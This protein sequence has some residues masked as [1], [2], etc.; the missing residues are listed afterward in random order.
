[1]LIYKCMFASLFFSD[2]N[3]KKT[4]LKLNELKPKQV[5]AQ[6]LKV[7]KTALLFENIN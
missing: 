6:T 2:K 1:M 5:E 3:L 7:Y 4:V